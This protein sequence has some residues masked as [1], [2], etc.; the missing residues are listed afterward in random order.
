MMLGNFVEQEWREN[1]RQVNLSRA[2]EISFREVKVL[3]HDAEV[4]ALSPQNVA[5]LPQ[6]FF[7]AHIRSHVAG[8]VVSGKEKFQFL[9]RLPSL[10]AAHHPADFG[11]LDVAADPS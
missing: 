11:S 8:A 9:A 1:I 7:H 10:V 6:H 5:D 4:D 2:L 3:T